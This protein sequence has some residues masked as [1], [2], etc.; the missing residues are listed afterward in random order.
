MI[1]YVV[2]SWHCQVL[3]NDSWFH[4]NEY[5]VAMNEGVDVV[6]VALLIL[7]MDDMESMFATINAISFSFF[8][9][10]YRSAWPF[11]AKYQ[12][13]IE[14]V[15]FVYISV[16]MIASHLLNSH[17]INYHFVCYYILKGQ[18]VTL[19]ISFLFIWIST[20]Y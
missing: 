2:L 12:L 9:Y 14:N 6:F 15:S 18:C 7:M 5:I 16:C 8:N 17:I 20:I 4:L 11:Q 10:N 1:F 13:A 19:P 3:K